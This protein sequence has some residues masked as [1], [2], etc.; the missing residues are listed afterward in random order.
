MSHLK[1]LTILALIAFVAFS[2]NKDDDPKP[3]DYP[4]T[5][6]EL[7]V[8]TPD[9]SNLVAALQKAD[10]ATTLNG[11]GPFTV[12]APTNAAFTTFLADNG[13]S[14]VDDVPVD[15][16]TQ[17]LLNHVI[18]GEVK[19]NQ[20][21]TGYVKTLADGPVDGSKLSM[22]L[23]ASSGVKINGISDVTTPDINATNG[24]IHI[25]DAVIGLPT[26]V[27]FAL[28]DSNFSTLT[29]ALTRA[30]L[31]FDYVSALSTPNGTDPA[32][33]TVFAPTND[34][35]ASLL[36]ELGVT[37]LDDIDEPTLKA[38]LDLHAVAGAN[39]LAAGLS[40]DMT[41]TTLGGDITANVTGGATLTDSNGRVSNITF[42]DVQAAN[43]VIHVIDKVLLPKLPPNIVG[44]ALDTP[45]LS[46]LV[47]ALQAADGNL[48]DVLNGPG[49]FTVLAPDND[50]FTAFLSDNGFASLADVPTDVLSQILL[51]HV[52]SGKVMSTD[53][54]D[55]GAGYASTSATG[56]GGNP[57][58][59]YFNTSDGVKFN[60]ISSVTTPDIEVTNGVIH[61][62][63]KV[64]GLPTVVDQAV[65]NPN[66]SSLVAAL[67]AADGDLVTVLGGEGPFT[68]L[69]PDNDAFAT[70]LHGAALGDVPTDALANLLLNHVISGVVTSTD[71]VS[72]EAGY[73]NTLA[74]GPN[75]NKL[76]LYYNTTDGVKF[77][78]V[79]SVSKADIVTS[80]GI[81]HAVDAVIPIPTVVTFATADPN[82]STLVSALTTLTPNTDFVATL[83]GTGPFT[84][85]APTNAAFDALGTPP[86]E[87]VLTQVL[88]HHVVSG[89]YQSGDLNQSGDTTVPTLQGDN[90]T[91]TL[92]GTGGNIADMTDGA[93]NTD[94]GIIKVNVQAGNGVIHVINKVLLPSS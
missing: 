21:Q 51:N 83:S 6:T 35:F 22:Y 13:F 49:P 46:I 52:I 59:I 5:I 84:V 26:V 7:A 88:L 66:F 58:S 31:T 44:K 45:S 3:I 10:L 43:G 41:V 70:Y 32:P 74:V 24:V 34:A 81:I 50:A 48:V 18:L 56:A 40:D 92:P 67:G 91:I 87:P 55:A 93:G 65:A 89:N 25:V 79:S 94:I 75:D 71:L 12:F 76:S 64:I 85:F 37:S 16:L 54:V 27:D 60:G 4:E 14:S 80:N 39:V 86:A 9:L 38:A 57:M 68:V 20:I 33:F 78:D 73:T 17:I 15:V 28:A 63:N 42:T 53:L 90:I 47:E 8:A 1:K 82:F 62:V 19:S 2:C 36:T 61:I 11:A 69:A 77:N 30:D 29:S 72:E 23:D